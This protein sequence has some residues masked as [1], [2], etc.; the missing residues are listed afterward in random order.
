MAGSKGKG[1]V[2]SFVESIMRE[3]GLKTALYTSPHLV[4][5]RE[6]LKLDG[7]SLS[8]AAF[9]RAVLDVHDRLEPRVSELPGFFRLLTLMAFDVM[10]KRQEKGALDVAIVE[11]GMGGRFDTTNVIERPAVTAITSLALEHVASLGPSLKDIAN[12]KAG[13]AKTGVPLISVPQH[14][15]AAQALIENATQVDC[16]LSFVESLE[17]EL[18]ECNIVLGN[19]HGPLESH[20]WLRNRR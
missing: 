6:R 20:N 19:N 3:H 17:Q 14:S 18:P 10:L 2:A 8:L 11:V 16:P 4:H 12:H 9:S 15:D 7:R 5:P 1:S 13:I